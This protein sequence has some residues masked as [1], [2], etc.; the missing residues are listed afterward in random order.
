MH[1]RSA[2]L[3]IVLLTLFFPLIFIP[4]LEAK[5]T[6]WKTSIS[7]DEMTGKKS[8]YAYSPEVGPT[9]QMN[10]PYQDVKASLVVGYDGKDEWVY[11]GFTEVPNL[12]TTG[13][14]FGTRVK[15]D[16][17]IENETLVQK[18]GE[19]F[20]H[21]HGDRFAIPKI[22]NCNSVLV[23]LPW[24]GNGKVYFKFPLNGSSAALKQ[25]RNMVK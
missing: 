13:S 21:F 5:Q 18:P 6:S 12:N 10:W 11:I 20:I 8:A 24:Y 17:T 23:E 16:E 25:I 19:R 4:V 14:G 22:E 15:W 1:G 3:L 2:T 7:V 9:K